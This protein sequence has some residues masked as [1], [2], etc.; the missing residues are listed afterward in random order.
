MAHFSGVGESS[1]GVDH[2]NQPH[3]DYFDFQDPLYGHMDGSMAS[4]YDMYDVDFGQN[5]Q[6]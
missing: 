3:L 4:S 2:A 6:I 5:C 1:V